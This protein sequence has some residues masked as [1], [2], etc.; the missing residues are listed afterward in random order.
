MTAAGDANDVKVRTS[1]NP[2]G[3]TADRMTGTDVRAL[4][5]YLAEQS[6][7]GPSS[8]GTDW[9]LTGPCW[10]KNRARPTGAGNHID[11][12][13]HLFCVKGFPWR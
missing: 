12:M 4:V 9:A 7:P 3:T 10:P 6:R 11:M 5:Q 8:P 13:Y 2:D 1:A